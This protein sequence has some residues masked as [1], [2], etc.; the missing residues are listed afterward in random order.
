MTL[1]KPLREVFAFFE[2]P[3][4]LGRITPPWL[5]F[6]IVNPDA[7]EMNAGAEINYVIGWMG[8]PMKWKTI[9]KSYDP[10]HQ[11]IDEQAR[12]PYALWHHEHTFEETP[13]GVLIG[14]RVDYKLPFGPLGGIA[15]ALVVKRQLRAIFR[16]RQQAIASAMSLAT[17]SEALISPIVQSRL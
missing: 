10:P 13:D 2:D 16:Y 4:N 1:R 15:H 9:I 8:L 12:G 5:N 3:R 7:I 14:D 6:R 17:P 11:F